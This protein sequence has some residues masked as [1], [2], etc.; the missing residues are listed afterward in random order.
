MLIAGQSGTGKSTSALACL[1]A[2]FKYL[3]EDFVGLERLHDGSFIGH[4]LYN[5]AFLETKHLERFPYLGPHVMRGMAHEKKSVVILSNVFP[6]RLERAVPIRFLLL[7]SVVDSPETRILAAGKSR[8][9]MAL[10]LSSILKFPSPGAR[11]FDRL[12][13]LVE[14]VPCYDLEL[15]RDLNSTP[16]RLKE[17][18]AVGGRLAS[19]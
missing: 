5:S 3:S 14:Q 4:S 9:L 2:G 8:A 1:F 19:A 11:G 17:L 16:R 15:G 10:G 18:L 13:Q 12:A 7:T 6:E